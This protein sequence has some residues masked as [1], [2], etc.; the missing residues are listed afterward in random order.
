M[1]RI[2]LKNWNGQF[3]NKGVLDRIRRKIEGGQA[4]GTVLVDCEDAVL[5][6]EQL[7]YLQAG[8][9]PHKVRFCGSISTLPYPVPENTV[10]P[11]PGTRKKK[12]NP[13]MN[14]EGTND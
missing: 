6:K 7:A 1:V 14:R 8:Y 2:E 9:A 4:S 13:R 12:R 5:T 3:H 10:R 11:E